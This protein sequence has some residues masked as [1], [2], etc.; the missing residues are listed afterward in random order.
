MFQNKGFGGFG[1]STPFG[2]NNA[3]QSGSAFGATAPGTGG[4]LFGGAAS[5]STSTGG[6][7]FGAGAT[8]TPG[9]TSGFGNT[10]FSF[11]QTASNQN[12]AQ[13]QQAAAGGGGGLFGGG[14]LSQSS[15]IFS[16]PTSSTS[17]SAFGFG[18]G[19]STPQTGGLFGATNANTSTN[20][21]GASAANTSG[22]S[23]GASQQQQTGTSIKF[24]PPPGSDTMMKGGQTQSI[25]TKHQCITAMKEYEA[26]SLEE[27][28][29]ED[30]LANRKGPSQTP[31]G[32]APTGGLFGATSQTSQASTGFGFGQQKPATGFGGGSF[33]TTSTAGGGLFGQQQTAAAPGNTGGL[34]GAS[35]PSLFGTTTTSTASTGFGGFGQT[36]AASTSLFGANNQ[37]KPTLFG[38][39]ATTQA[40]GGGLF[41][42]GATQTSTAGFGAPSTGFSAGFGATAQPATGGIFGG[43]NKPGFGQTATS[44]G[45]GGFG[46]TA[47]PAAGTGGLFGKST[48]ATG[49]TGFGG[50]GQNTTA[51]F[52]AT[53]NTGGGLFGAKPTG[54]GQTAGGGLT[55]G[56]GTS[57][58]LTGGLNAGVFGNAQKPGGLN[59]G[60]NTGFASSTGFA[61]GN[62]LGGG[63]NLGT[64]S[65]VNPDL[66][67]AAGQQAQVQQQLALLSS[68]PYGDTTLVRNLQSDKKV[69]EQRLKPTSAQAQRASLA[70]SAQFRVS[71]RPTSKIKPKPLPSL[72][73]G[74]NQLFEGL[75]DDDF[76]FGNDSFI[77][78]RSVKKLVIRSHDSSGCKSPSVAQDE[79]S[80]SSKDLVTN[81]HPQFLASKQS[82][83]D[84]RPFEEAPPTNTY[85][86]GN[87]SLDDTIMELNAKNKLV[88]SLDADSTTD[89]DDL[90]D[91]V[92][93]VEGP[94][95]AA[96]IVLRRHGYFTMPSLE[97]LA[98]M[99]DDEGA[100]LVENFVVGREGYGNVLFPGKTDVANLNLD[101]IV[102]FRRK[103]V[104]IY[105]DDDNKP[106]VGD[107]LNKRA[108]VTLDCVWPVDKSSHKLIK[109]P[110]RLVDMNYQEKIEK[111]S[112]KIG[113]K[114]ID[115]RPETGSWVFE[116]KHFSKYGLVDD[117]DDEEDAAKKGESVTGKPKTMMPLAKADLATSK[118]KVAK[119]VVGASEEKEEVIFEKEADETMEETRVLSA[120]THV[121]AA[122]AEEEEEEAGD[123]HQ[124]PS[125]HRLAT[126]LGVT[127]HHLQLQKASFFG[128]DEQEDMDMELTTAYGGFLSPM[129]TAHPT[130][131]HTPAAVSAGLKS[132]ITG[133]APSFGALPWS[134]SVPRVPITPTPAL[135]DAPKLLAPKRPAFDSNNMSAMLFGEKSPVRS[136]KD[137][138]AMHMLIPSGLTAM[139]KPK[140]MLGTRLPRHVPALKESVIQGKHSML[141]DAALVHGRHSRVGWS[142]GWTFVHNDRPLCPVDA[143]VISDPKTSSHQFL[144]GSTSGQGTSGAGYPVT[145]E[146]VVAPVEYE[147][148]GDQSE[149]L[150][151]LLEI[152]LKHSDTGDSSPC[153]AFKASAGVAALHR[154]AD[155]ASDLGSSTGGH[156]DAAGEVWSLCVA[157]WGDVPR[158]A[159]QEAS[160][161]GYFEQLVRKEAVS[162]WLE[163]VTEREVQVDALLANKHQG[164]SS[165]LAVFAYLTGRRLD[166]ACNRAQESGDHTVALL[167]AQATGADIGRQMLRTQLDQWQ[168]TKM[169]AHIDKEY[170]KIYALLAGQLVWPSSQ[171]DINVC[172]GLS[173]KRCFAL[174]LWYQCSATA[175]ISDA[176][177]QYEEA[178]QAE[179]CARP[180][181]GYLQEGEGV[182]PT[183]GH[184]D[185]CFHLLQ[186][187]C[188]KTHALDAL[189]SPSSVTANHLDY[190]LSWHL[191]CVLQALNFQHLSEQRVAVICC[192]YASQLEAAG[193]WHW[194]IF[195]LM[196]LNDPLRRCACVQAVLMRHIQLHP[197]DDSSERENFLT[198][199]LQ[200]PAAWLH[201]AKAVAA[202]SH[203]TH[204]EEAWH[205]L[206]AQKWNASHA[207]VTRHLAAQAIIHESYD[208]L[209]V[210]LAELGSPEVNCQIQNWSIGGK[211]YLDYINMIDT[212]HQLTQGEPSAYELE[213][214]QVEVS[215]LSKR[216]GSLVCRNATDRLC[217]SEM[218]KRTANLTYTLITMQSAQANVP[219]AAYFSGWQSVCDLPLPEDYALQE[220]HQLTGAHLLQ[221]T[222]DA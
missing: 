39:T 170:L 147:S 19:T 161:D 190:S 63:L 179:T 24:N 104:T 165:A 194:A 210:Y 101:E 135:E 69:Q 31:A 62:T 201:A 130:V 5:A 96:G 160:G 122:A 215:S 75:E 108:Q 159:G 221:I 163:S 87:T 203:G 2:A 204:E 46:A 176:L 133:K 114:F 64:A 162:S 83:I 117:S 43:A 174:F 184:R 99:V 185:I 128:D 213:K 35:K 80:T 139:N 56:F 34:F 1:S 183:E 81:L 82:D 22:F 157:L 199:Q 57:T 89:R 187:F 149:H 72:V 40:S 98:E 212:L 113:A 26:K 10:G 138:D 142:A 88:Q 195:V 127:P 218:A 78:R 68:M 95:H 29:V 188:N 169:D 67:G 112:V 154:Y 105:P 58:G 167:S 33:G 115:Y 198:T 8:Q 175:T 12:A 143:H 172:D 9:N 196:H 131:K 13:P 14:G 54:F 23:M 153:P 120:S 59:F 55:T 164:L 191:L 90:S 217:Q 47:Q 37:A 189:L 71:P 50:F 77:P 85:K 17:T 44:T 186:L 150:E 4:G 73:A 158:P 119:S 211:V 3:N 41:G 76:S 16:T 97:E 38:Q 49:T 107:A 74:K 220:L 205:L 45:F 102:H 141:M 100:C 202:R 171:G 126:S 30:Y 86:T 129:A 178:F 110:V 84:S 116:V 52:G 123:V 168:Q 28:R 192:S 93:D 156:L 173:W 132:A 51:G 109:D 18:G 118:L 92:S 53:A 155:M 206:R 177:L 200:L 25:S 222:Q 65:A 61:G 148:V 36:P 66:S 21:F 103:E 145:L 140:K 20:V 106:D 134:P 79:G 11:G 180:S 42:G 32:S 70:V 137:S 144:L 124:V 91:N 27:L 7:M 182:Q 60:A 94:P 125:S 207:V 219:T 216:I 166:D 111:A 193:L 15:G 146:K 209:K 121:S 214:L 152:Q 197:D 48:A 181:P 151:A 136:A 6:G 208:Q